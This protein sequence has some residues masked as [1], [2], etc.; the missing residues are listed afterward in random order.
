MSIWAKIVE[1]D[2][3]GYRPCKLVMV[4]DQ[5]RKQVDLKHDRNGPEIE[6][7]YDTEDA[8]LGFVDGRDLCGDCAA[9]I[10]ARLSPMDAANE[11]AP[12]ELSKEP[13]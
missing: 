6:E 1:N 5:C 10:K 7:I 3:Y 8:H 12:G 9:R 13:S 11:L 2:L 4:C